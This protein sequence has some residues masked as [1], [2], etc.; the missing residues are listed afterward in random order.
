[1]GLRT[2]DETPGGQRVN[3]GPTSRSDCLSTREGHLYIDELDT[4]E[5]AA[6]FGTPLFVLSET[7]LRRNVRRF[8]AAF[9]AEWEGPVDVMPAFKANTTLASRRVLTDEGAGADVYS[10]GELEGVLSTPVD[11]ARVSVNGGGKSRDYLAHCVHEGVRITVE[12]VD[13]IELIQAVAAEQNRTAKI[14]LRVKPTV[15]NLWRPTDFSQL[16]VPID[17]AIQVYK[18]GIPPE[19]LVEMGRRAIAAPNIDMVGL[20]VHQGRHH[21]SLWFWEGL[22]SRFGKL[23][24]ELVAAW[25][26]WQP[27]EI[28]IGGG[29][30]SPRDP[31]NEELPRS[32]FVLTAL[33]FPL[34]AGLRGLG[35]RLYHRALAGLVPVLSSH[36]FRA[37]PP[38]IE[39]YA[40]TSVRTLRR[41]LQAARVSTAGVRLQ[42]EPGRSMYGDAG[43]HLARVK[44]VKRQSQPFPYAWVLTDTTTFF[45]AGGHFERSRF[46][47]VVANK[48]DRPVA[49]TADLVGHS[50]FADQIV[51]GARL[52]EVVPG[53]VIA[54]LE[55][56]AYQESSASNFNAL[57]RP[58]TVMVCGDQ[59]DVVRRAETVEDVYR[60]DLTPLRMHRFQGAHSDPV[61][62]KIQ[63]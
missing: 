33:G 7:Q 26:G 24:G 42:I 27:Q 16:T 63:P 15:P 39:Q 3:E 13:E 40:A 50:C 44:T 36:R 5:L 30:P 22:M 25:D 34:L 62:M 12:D 29:W 17:L 21:A 14:R 1:M 48:A 61:A 8:R 52:P 58:A 4:V 19:F 51:L 10:P 37:T 23:A 32:E 31:L 47:H 6:R 46:R 41:E 57:P 43:I 35:A 28:D 59:A 49:M 54:L 9:A 53:D 2:T 56:G 38:S 20:H 45:L 55:T 60:R 11:R 18:S